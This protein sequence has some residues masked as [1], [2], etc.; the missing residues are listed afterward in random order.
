[1]VRSR[2]SMPLPSS[3]MIDDPELT[4]PLDFANLPADITPADFF[5]GIAEALKDE[6]APAGAAPDKM[7]L[8]IS[9]AEGGTWAM[10]FVAGRLAIDPGTAAKSPMQISTSVEDFRAFAAGSIRDA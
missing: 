3:Y 7:L 5:A 10:G 9:G 2:R 1:M 4:M 8:H 6:P